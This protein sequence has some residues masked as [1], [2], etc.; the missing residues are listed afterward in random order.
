MA[1][2]PIAIPWPHHHFDSTVMTNAKLNYVVDF[3]MGI[4]FC[5][6]ALSGLVIF[7]FL[8]RGARQGGFQEFFG[9]TKGTWTTMHNWMGI[10]LILFVLIHLILH[11]RWIFSMTKAIFKGKK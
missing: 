7:L 2:F 8:P 5:I 6:T 11:W 1:E 3:L 10:L 4:S 9:I